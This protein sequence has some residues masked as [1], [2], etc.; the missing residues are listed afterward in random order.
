MHRRAEE[1]K[2]RIRV[3]RAA[4]ASVL[5]D[6]CTQLGYLSTPAEV[7][8]RLEG[9]FGH[10]DHVVFIAELDSGRVVGFLHGF[11]GMVLETGPRADILGLVIDSA[12]RGQ[13]IGK[14][15]V[16][17]AERWAQS[18]GHRGLHVRC[19]VVRTATHAFYE[20]LGFECYKTQKN[21]Q[22]KL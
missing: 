7:A 18:K 12:H 11:S 9:V 16:A 19:N 6:L 3:A 20:G 8:E 15:L 1:A 5:A 21:F 10:P 13:G 14:S 4:D 22:K 17:E 2:A